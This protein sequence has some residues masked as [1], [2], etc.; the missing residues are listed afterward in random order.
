[1]TSKIRLHGVPLSGHVHKVDLFLRLLG[2]P[3]DTVEAGGERRDT[4]DFRSLN[5]LGQIPVLEDGGLVL[6]DSNA[7][8]VY[9]AKRY[10]REGRWLPEAPAE[11]ARVQ[12]W[13]SISA[14]EIRFGP[15]NARA[16][17]LF[18][19]QT[20][21][22]DA[23]AVAARLLGFMDATLADQA[24]LAGA[25]PS[26]AD[27][28]CYPYLVVTPEG[29][30]DLEPYPAVRAWIARFEALPGVKPMPWAA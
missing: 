6:A 28:A 21:L 12:R 27:V 13:L 17:R 22:A 4:D 26:L 11:A 10:D 19:L 29:G 16:V 5:P 30:V 14:G 3:F 18:G 15:A 24:W 1:M 9:L 8:L 20:D 2:L 7:I 23:Q 25:S